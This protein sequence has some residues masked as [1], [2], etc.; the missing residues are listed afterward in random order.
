MIK[1]KGQPDREGVAPPALKRMSD[2]EYAAYCEAFGAIKSDYQAL[3]LIGDKLR[4][5]ETSAR[6]LGPLDP[7]APLPVMT[8]PAFR[9]TETAPGA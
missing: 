8:I 3:C 1:R 4:E 9:L 2:T 5:V 6:N 7:P